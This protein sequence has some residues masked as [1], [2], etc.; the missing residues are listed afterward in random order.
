MSPY[1]VYMT[2]ILVF[3]DS[4][5]ESGDMKRIIE[6]VHPDAEYVIHLGDGAED[7]ERLSPH[8]P[9]QAFVGVKGNCDWLRGFDYNGDHRVLDMEG[10][11][12]F[13]CHGHR[14]GVKNGGYSLLISAAITQNADIA[15][16]GHT[17]HSEYLTVPKPGRD[18]LNEKGAVIHILNPGSISRPR[19]GEIAGKS[20]A[21]ILLDGKGGIKISLH[22]AGIKGNL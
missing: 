4:H 22:S 10:V 5:G 8:F 15:L 21:V 18:D 16:F 14:H 7:I 11:R 2:K 6:S 9:R 1:G 20:Y 19:G 12:I 17:H 3:S 13:I